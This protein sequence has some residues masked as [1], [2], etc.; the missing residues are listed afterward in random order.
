MGIDEDGEFIYNIR[1]LCL[2]PNN[3]LG[4]SVH[5]AETIYFDAG[6]KAKVL[7]DSVYFYSTD[8]LIIFV[9]ELC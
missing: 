9:D 8:S 7:F 5:K 3:S 4:K 2:S 1:I 6:R